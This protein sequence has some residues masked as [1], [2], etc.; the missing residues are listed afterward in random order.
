MLSSPLNPIPTIS[1]SMARARV[2]P[3]ND[4]SFTND[5]DLLPRTSIPTSAVGLSSG[6]NSVSSFTS[7][8]MSDFWLLEVLS[9]VL[10]LAEEIFLKG[11]CDLVAAGLG[12]FSRV[13]SMCFQLAEYSVLLAGSL[14][15]L[16]P[17]GF[18]FVLNFFFLSVF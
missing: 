4:V 13:N 18:F 5:D 17:T 15:T 3:W 12:S 10:F 7:N 2:N 9:G 16:G 14:A 1:Q 11:L 6:S 8:Q